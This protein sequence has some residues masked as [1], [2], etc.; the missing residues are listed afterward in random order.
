MVLASDEAI[1]VAGNF[2]APDVRLIIPASEIVG[3]S[4]L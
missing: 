1:A 4:E 2:N 3:D